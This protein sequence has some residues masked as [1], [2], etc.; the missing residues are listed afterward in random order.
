MKK[1]GVFCAGNLGREVYDMVAR[2]NTKEVRWSEIFF[3]DNHPRSEKYYGKQVYSLEEFERNGEDI[4]F[5]IANGEPSVREEIYMQLKRSEYKLATIIDPTAIVSETA[6]LGEGVIITAFSTISSNVC[7]AENVLIQSYICVGHDIKV[8]ANS[9]ISANAAIGGGT[10]I[11]RNA[12]IGMG[13]AVRENL[14]IEDGS[15]VGMGAVVFNDV[16]AG[17]TMIGNPARVTRGNDDKKVFR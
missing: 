17:T 4:E 1:L 12:F 2:I 13:A 15:V 9:V 10:C 7:I 14:R 3:I 16:A 8:G 5:I 11:G 6:T